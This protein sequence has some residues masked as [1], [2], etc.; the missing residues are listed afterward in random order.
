[1]ADETATAVLDQ[2]TETAGVE[3]ETPNGET[4]LLDTEADTDAGDDSEPQSFTREQ[5]EAEKAQALADFRAQAEAEAQEQAKVQ[6]KRQVDS[7]WE[8][9]SGEFGMRSFR[10]LAAWAARQ[11]EAGKSQDEIAAMVQQ[12]AVKGFLD[13]FRSTAKPYL[14]HEAFTE[15]NTAGQGV[16]DEMFPNWK[17]SRDTEQKLRDAISSGDGGKAMKGLLAYM[18]QAI[19]EAD[20]PAK[21]KAEVEA[22]KK[23]TE[24][25]KEVQKL[26]RG[27][28]G[29]N[30]SRSSGN[31]VPSRMTLAEIDAMPTAKWLA[32]PKAQRDK[33][34]SDARTSR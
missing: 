15:M 4:M 12:V 23:K 27:A 34:L 22:S 25:A 1:M 2:T 6:A 19:D 33:L 31:A 9:F 5:V 20:V 13:S 29:T 21:V 3:A 7:Q 24:A 8:S 17:P 16:I 14:Y 11:S 32:L 10:N 26:Q 28:D 30:P 18:R